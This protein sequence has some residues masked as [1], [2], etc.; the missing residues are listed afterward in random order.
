MS[1][2]INGRTAVHAASAGV[3]NA[4]SVNYTGVTQTPQAYPSSA[5]SKD[6]TNAAKTVFVNGYPIG[7]AHSYFARSYGDQAGT[8]GGIYSGTVSGKASFLTSS[9]NVFIEGLSAVR[10]NDLMTSNGG[11]TPPVV[12]QQK[13]GM[14]VS[15]ETAP[16]KACE[17]LQESDYYLVIEMNDNE[18]VVEF[19]EFS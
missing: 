16:T 11:N 19:I 8:G 7:H 5:F 1:V 18:G 6:I 2:Y 4:I 15:F 3:I 17:A 9:P 14:A 10:A 13:L 12:L